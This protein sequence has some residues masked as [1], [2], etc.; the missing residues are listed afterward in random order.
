VTLTEAAIHELLQRARTGDE[1]AA[2]SL[3]GGMRDR[4]FRWALVMTRDSDDA[5]DVAQQVSMSV[6][7]SLNDFEAR[8]SFSTWLYAVVRNTS[9]ELMRKSARRNA[10]PL[11][12]DIVDPMLSSST[13]DRLTA[14][15]NQ[16]IAAI[17]RAFFADLPPRQRELIELVDTEG[18][19][20]AE[21]ARMIGIEPETARVHLLRARR[22]LRSRMLEA[23]PEMFI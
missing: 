6:H 19:S 3:I 16:R 10:T 12:D 4:V 5:E 22:T 15:G 7:K 11:N 2:A 14:I 17:V 1:A 13:S 9:V 20:A 8:S 18:Y 23:H 21:A